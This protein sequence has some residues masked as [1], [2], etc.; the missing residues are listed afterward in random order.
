MAAVFSMLISLI[1]NTGIG[2]TTLA[3]KLVRQGNFAL[4][5]EQHNERPFQALAKT[6]TRYALANQMDYLL[7]RA[8]Q[9]TTSRKSAQTTLLDGGLE[10]DFYG[11]TRLFAARAMLTPAEFDLCRRLYR[12]IR[13]CLPL[14]DLFIALEAPLEVIRARLIARGRINLTRPDDVSLLQTYLNEWLMTLPPERLLRL[15]VSQATPTYDEIL[16]DLLAE[17]RARLKE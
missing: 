9:E 16:P 13:A 14:P 12:Q 11:F 3:Q 1:G 5:L 4:A 17:I 10:Q 2:K 7:L 8:E 6:N 15:D